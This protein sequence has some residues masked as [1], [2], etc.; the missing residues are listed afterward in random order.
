MLVGVDDNKECDILLLQMEFL[1]NKSWNGWRRVGTTT[2]IRSLP[3]KR[4]TSQRK[5]LLD[6][7]QQ[8][9]GHLDAD[10]LYR[11]AR[12]LGHTISLS[13]VY[14]NLKLFKERG[15]VAERHFGEEHHHYE[16]KPVGEHHHLVCLGCGEVTEFMSRLIK[17][18][19]RQVE[20]ESGFVITDAEIRMRGYCPHCRQNMG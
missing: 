19:K 12:E 9:D 1:C 16:A 11:R 17:Q 4:A 6:L 15:L 2:R 13:T 3:G 18:M 20:L 7:I 10:E 14:R 5:I 8:A